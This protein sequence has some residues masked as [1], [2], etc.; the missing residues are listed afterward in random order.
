M[1][2]QDF[3]KLGLV[4]FFILLSSAYASEKCKT[5]HSHVKAKCGALPSDPRSGA[6]IDPSC[7]TAV[8]D[9]CINA[10]S[11]QEGGDSTRRWECENLKAK[12]PKFLEQKGSTGSDNIYVPPSHLPGAEG[13]GAE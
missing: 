1:K 8:I 10:C 2:S 11:G 7:N 12:M 6:S 3:A 13:I 4:G 5:D 9:A